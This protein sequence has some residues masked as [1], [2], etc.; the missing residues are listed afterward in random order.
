[1]DEEFGT[2]KILIVQADPVRRAALAVFLEPYF[3]TETASTAS[4]GLY[5]VSQWSPDLAILDVPLPDLD[6]VYLLR[7]LRARLPACPVIVIAAVGRMDSVREL[8]AL[9][10][11]SLF[12]KPIQVEKLLD[13]ISNLLPA[14]NGSVPGLPPLCRHICKAIEHLHRDSM[15]VVTVQGLAEAIG[16]S[17]SRLAHLFRAKTRMTVRE[18]LAKVRVEVAKRTLLETRD[19]L[20]RISEAVGFS[21]AS[22]LSRVFKKYA[23]RRPGEYRHAGLARGVV[24]TPRQ[25]C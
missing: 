4:D 5:L 22:H 12:P 9:G 1:M 24:E 2:S 16:I 13:R 8:T 7:V 15:Q 3:R 19:S 14:G 6:G 21:D 18:F 23:G 17:A 11:A 20:E 25:P 10:V